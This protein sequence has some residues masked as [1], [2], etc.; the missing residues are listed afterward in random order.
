LTTGDPSSSARLGERFLQLPLGD[1]ER[2]E[3]P[4]WRLLHDARNDGRKPISFAK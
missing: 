3:W 1:V 2:V 4:N